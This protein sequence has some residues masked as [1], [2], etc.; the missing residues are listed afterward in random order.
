MRKNDDP[1]N[2]DLERNDDS[3]LR[4]QAV[5]MRFGG[6]KVLDAVS[7]SLAPGDLSGLIGPNGAGK[8]TLFDILAGERRPTSGRVFLRGH[9]VEKAAAHS[10][11]QSGM[12]RTF[13]IPRPFAAMSVLENVMLGCQ[14]HAG[15]HLWANWFAAQRVLRIEAAA[16]V[17]AMEILQFVTLSNLAQQPAGVLSGGQRK[18]LELARVLMAEPRLILLDEP[19]AG[20]NPALL[21]VIIERIAALNRRGISFLI[22][23]HNMDVIA[24][25]CRHVFVMAAGAML[26]E[27]KPSEVTRD[28]RVIDAY[29]GGPAQ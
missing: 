27:G 9:A 10:R 14:N 13:Q 24:R 26:C 1:V 25:L 20:V 19:A 3:L 8:S 4:A 17:R 11:L 7:L 28:P 2:D 23:E 21:E 29:L 22:V 15:E 18:L 6:V 16:Q 12:G 5:S